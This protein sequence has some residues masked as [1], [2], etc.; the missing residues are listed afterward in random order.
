MYVVTYETSS[1][2]NLSFF[3]NMRCFIMFVDTVCVFFFLFNFLRKKIQMN[4]S[5][6]RTWQEPLLNMERS[7]CSRIG[8]INGTMYITTTLTL[9]HPRRPTICPWVSE[10]DPNPNLCVNFIWC[11][12]GLSTYVIEQQPSSYPLAKDEQGWHVM[13]G[14]N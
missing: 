6:N 2:S 8:L 9:T 12:K 10:D 4:V 5:K 13:G 1:L 3:C 7:V 14:K 11:P